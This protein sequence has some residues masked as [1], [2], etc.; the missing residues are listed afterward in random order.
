MKLFSM[1]G[2]H[3]CLRGKKMIDSLPSL[4]SLRWII[5]FKKRSNTQK[6]VDFESL[7][8]GARSFH[9]INL[10]KAGKGV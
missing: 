5:F 7:K 4:V 2:C 3:D 10:G 8:S 1:F 6:I 9:H